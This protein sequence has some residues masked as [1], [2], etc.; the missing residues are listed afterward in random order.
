M[1][2]TVKISAWQLMT[3]LLV[4]RVA[5]ALTYTGGSAGVAHGTDRMAALLLEAAFALLLFLPTLWYSRAAQGIGALEYAY[6][7]FGKGGAVVAVLYS[8]YCLYIQSLDL[9]QFDHFAAAA[10]SPE[11]SRPVL[12]IVLVMAAFI[13][14]FYG[15]E[16]VA[17]TASVIALLM[18]AAIVFLTVCLLPD[19]KRLHFPPL[20]YGGVTP[21][22]TGALESLPR[23]LELGLIALLVPYVKGVGKGL[24]AGVLFSTAVVLVMQATLVGV[25][26]DYNEMV[27]YPYYTAAT[28]AQSSLIQRLDILVTAVW[29]AGIFVKMSLMAVIFLGCMRQ[30]FGD[31]WKLLY[32]SA[33]GASVLAVGLLLGDRMLEAEYGFLWVISMSLLLLFAVALPVILLGANALRERRA[34]AE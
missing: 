29:L 22:L 8:L 20:F 16:A 17:R 12:C 6:V 26:G 31:K 7:Q 33:G 1:E 34:K 18:I 24:S 10:T 2:K 4:G 5:A 9:M 3:L 21:I 13:A 32:V 27:T 25:L 15:L 19:M 30:A 23:F 11:L 14:A 28:L